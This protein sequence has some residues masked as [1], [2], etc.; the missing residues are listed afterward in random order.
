MSISIYEICPHHV[1]SY[2]YVCIGQDEYDIC[3][4]VKFLDPGNLVSG[5]DIKLCVRDGQIYLNTVLL[6]KSELSNG[7]V[8]ESKPCESK[9][10]ESMEITALIQREAVER[11][12]ER[13]REN[14]NDIPRK[15]KFTNIN[16]IPDPTNT[17]YPNL[18][19][20]RFGFCGEYDMNKV[21]SN[22]SEQ[23]RETILAKDYMSLD[24]TG[25]TIT[26]NGIMLTDVELQAGLLES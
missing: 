23:R 21:I 1:P 2:G 22:L 11:T 24:F 10:S 25:T 17:L 14:K 4:V 15:Q 20:R 19:G 5:T 16:T 26:I 13:Q 6:T 12:T 7:H 18:R 8:K 3:D 9:T